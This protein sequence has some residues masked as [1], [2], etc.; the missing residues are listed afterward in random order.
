MSAV[1]FTFKFG[2]SKWRHTCIRAYTHIQA[3]LR[4][5]KHVCTN[6]STQERCRKVKQ[7]HYRDTLLTCYKENALDTK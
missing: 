4:T 3:H 7:S 5:L 1:G 6:R 2:A